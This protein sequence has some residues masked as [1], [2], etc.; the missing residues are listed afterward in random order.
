M[1]KQAIYEKMNSRNTALLVIDVV[2]GCCHKDCEEPKWGIA[3]SKIRKMVPRLK[4][5]IELYRKNFSG[6][7]CFAKIVPW[8]KEFLTDNINELYIDPEAYCYSDDKTGF[9]EKFYLVEPQKG[10]F[11]FTK[12]HYD[13]FTNED[14][15]KELA[16]RKIRYIIVAGIFTDGC[17]LSTIISGFSK[18]FNFV[19][20]NDLIETTDKKIRQ[21]LQNILKQFTFPVM[22]GKTINSKDFLNTIK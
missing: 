4:S 3:F 13:C 19:I 1:R 10:D 5:F 18:G 14:F 17:I 7:I 8:Q 15:N 6:L 9:P 16:K 22:Y 21:D 20:L 11:V 2:N 12:N